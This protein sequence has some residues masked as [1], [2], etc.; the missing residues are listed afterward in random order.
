MYFNVAVTVTKFQLKSVQIFKVV[1][2]FITFIYRPL[3]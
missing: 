1:Q 2:Y 3:H